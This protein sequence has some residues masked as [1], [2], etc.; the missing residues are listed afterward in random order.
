MLRTIKVNFEN[1]NEIIAWTI[2]WIYLDL[3]HY[4]QNFDCFTNIDF[5][6]MVLNFK[7]FFCKGCLDLAMLCLN[8]NN[9][10]FITIKGVDYCGI[11][12]DISACKTIHLLGNSVLYN[13]GYIW[14]AYQ[15]NQWVKFSET[16]ILSTI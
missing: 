9:I 10:A 12:K 8:I 14:D 5:F 6:I 4:I 11:I 1:H 2:L 13:C 16:T 3:W 7:I 15:N